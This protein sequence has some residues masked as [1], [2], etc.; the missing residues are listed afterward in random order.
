MSLLC[1]VYFFES[2]V[3]IKNLNLAKVVYPSWE[4]EKQARGFLFK[5]LIDKVVRHAYWQFCV[6]SA[7][8]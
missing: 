1:L 2:Q 5:V 6:R 4:V 7:T 3:E 8:W